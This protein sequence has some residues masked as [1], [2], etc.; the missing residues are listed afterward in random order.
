MKTPAYAASAA[1]Y[2]ALARARLP[3]FL[4][5]YV[6]GGATDE[7]TLTANVRDWQQVDLR[8]RVLIDVQQ[9]DTRTTL[10]G[11]FCALPLVPDT[12]G[13]ACIFRIEQTLENQRT[14]PQAAKPL[15]IR[16]GHGG[17]ELTV[18]PD[19]EGVEVLQLRGLRAETAKRQRLT[20]H[21]DIPQPAGAQGLVVSN[22][23]GR[24]L[25]GVSSTA[26]KLPEIVQGVGDQIEVLVDGGI[27]SGTDLFRALALGARGVL[28]G[29]PWAW[30]LAAAGEAGVAA[31]IASWQRELSLAMT[32]A[33]VT[34]IADIGPDN[35]DQP[36]RSAAL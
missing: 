26:R 30:A 10:A 20:A 12:D 35:L 31:L 4:L 1:D 11:Q 34:R 6:D 5:D 28:I 22:H 21:D 32:L 27:R 25:D 2:H 33:G 16:P 15:D 14:R 36:A 24:Q 7:Q 8:Q 3:A 29:R 13:L 23:G 9:V 17:I 18:D 19:L